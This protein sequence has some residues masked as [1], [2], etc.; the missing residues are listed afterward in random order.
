MFRLC[1]VKV[2]NEMRKNP[3]LI[4]GVLKNVL[5]C[6]SGTRRVVQ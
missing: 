2:K 4:V 5:G 1:S 3:R 6:K